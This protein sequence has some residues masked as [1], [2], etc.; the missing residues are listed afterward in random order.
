LMEK[1]SS[2]KRGTMVLATVK[3][4]VHDIGKNLVDII[5]TNNGYKIINL[6]IR[7]PL[8]T[9]LNAVEEHKADAIGMSGLLVKSTAIMKENLE[10]MNER[11]LTTPVVLGGAALTRKFVEGDL[12]SIYQGHVAYANDAFDGL[13]FMENL[14]KLKTIQRDA[15]NAGKKVEISA[16]ISI[17]SSTTKTIL[18]EA[19]IPSPPFWGSKVIENINLDEVFSYINDI[20]LI[21]GQ[22]QVYKGKKSEAE[23]QEFLKENIYPELEALKLKVKS[24]KLLTPKLV[25]GYFPCQS[26]ENQK[27]LSVDGMN[28]LSTHVS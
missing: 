23:Y 8:D 18:P 2:Q 9:I 22:W 16:K 17:Q 19:L 21:K 13:R 12:R 15:V 14:S 10:I 20:A 27:I 3:G 11:G 25:Y 7:V 26:Y 5:L 1:T 24:D 6:G 28:I 4:D